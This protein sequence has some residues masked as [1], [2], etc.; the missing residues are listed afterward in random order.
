[1]DRKET[2]RLYV[3]ATMRQFIPGIHITLDDAGEP[4]D[5]FGVMPVPYGSYEAAMKAEQEHKARYG[6]SKSFWD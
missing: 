3:Q 5:S 1:M 4:P 6:S 2:W